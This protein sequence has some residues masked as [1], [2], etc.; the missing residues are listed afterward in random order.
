MLIGEVAERSGVSARMLRHYDRIGLVSPA[1][2]TAGGYRR[3]A[4]EDLARLFHVE[5]LRSLGLGLAEVAAL[6]DDPS[7]RPA[8]LVDRLIAR[9]RERLARETSLLH[10][11]TRVRASA[12]DGWADVLRTVALLRGL[13]AESPSARQRLALGLEGDEREAAAVVDAAL[14][15]A[16][17]NAAG[18][19]DWAL[20]Q[21]GDGVV[22][23]L[24]D[25]LG[26]GEPDRR[27]R[28]VE[29]LQ[30][31]GTSRAQEALAAAD[32]HPDPFVRARALLARGRRGDVDAITGLVAL[33][34]E[35]RDDVEAADALTALAL[36]EEPIPV[37]AALRDA[38]D[39][40][41]EAARARL[42]AALAE[43]PGPEADALLRE[44]TEDPDRR[45][46][47][48]AAAL[49]RRRSEAPTGRE[50]AAGISRGG[51]PSPSR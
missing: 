47:L 42:V 4:E 21:I 15:E 6:L 35:G 43:I 49:L 25:A 16:D 7:Y 5:G 44:R 28:A 40:A 37:V 11:L 19:L 22:P 50:G 13:D 46:A 33:V 45:V 38:L 23:D 3:Y 41:D 34:V 31:L 12:P 14:A 24:V 10:D 29:A 20:A 26:S 51:R 8:E 27:R 39:G 17:P 2:R 36:R 18:A 32:P 1:Q 9:T 30:K 48:T